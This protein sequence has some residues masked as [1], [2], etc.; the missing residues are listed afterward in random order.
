MP[1]RFLLCLAATP[2]EAQRLSFDVPAGRLSDALIALAGQ[3]GV[4][5][6]ASDPGLAAIGVR[7]LNG[8]MTLRR[9]LALLLRGTG[10]GFQF[11]DARTVRIVRAAPAPRS[12]PRRAPPPPSAPDLPSEIIVTASKQ[13]VAL[14]RRAGHR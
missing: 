13:G 7:G 9:A 11:V 14:D 3:A 2:A 1:V 12:P 4:T 5:I 6:G 8:R 10:Y